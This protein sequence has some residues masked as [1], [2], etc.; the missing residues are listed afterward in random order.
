MAR[1][2]LGLLAFVAVAAIAQSPL[3]TITGTITDAQEARVPN[4]EVTARNLGTGI[5]Y[6]SVSSA[7][8]TYVLPNLPVGRYEVSATA[9]GFKIYRRTDVVLEVAHRLRLDIRLELG[10]LTETVTVTGEP[11]RVRTEDATLGTVVERQRIEELPLNGRHVFSLVRLVAG[12]RPI[13]R[14]LDGFAEVTN[15]G[16]SQI[17]FNGGPVYG[18]Q[19]FIDG[20]MNTVPVH[21]EI[22]VVP[23]ADAVEEFKV[24][25]N[26]L[27]AEFGQTSGGV[28]NVA[29]KSGT[30]ELHGSL[31]EFFRNDALDARNAFAT[32]RDPLTGRIKPVL[33]YNQYGGTVGG[34]IYVPQVY[35]GRN[36][37]FF[38]FGYEQWR[39][40]TSTLRRQT[41]PTEAQRNGDFST[42]Y[43]AAG[44]VIPLFDPATTRPNPAGSGFVRDPLPGNLVPRARM[45]AV[46]LKV[47]E[48]MPKPNVTPEVPLTNSLNF[49][50]L[51][52]D[53][54][55]QGV[56]NLRV[57]HRFSD[58][59]SVFFRYSGTRNTRQGRGWGLGVADPDTFARRDQRDNHNGIA[60]YTRVV[61]PSVINELK[62]NVTR[63]NL[64]FLHPSF[65]Q[66]LP[67]KLGLPAIVPRE[68]FPRVE[69]AGMLPLG[70]TNFAAGIRAQHYLQLADSLTVVRGRHNLKFG[71]DQR[72]FRLNWRRFGYISG[73]YTFTAALT[74]DPQRP[75]GTGFG[76]ATFLLG[77]VSGGLQEFLPAFSFHAWSNG[78][79]IQDDFK[80]TRRLTLNLG[81]RYDF[82]S[83]PVERHNRHS[84]FEP[85][86]INPETRMLGVLK[87]A[88][89]DDPRHFVNRDR[90]N[91]GPRFGF[92]YD[93]T[94]DGRTAVRG[95]YGLVYLL[96][97]SGDTQGDDSNAF[98]FSAQTSFVPVGG[99]PFKAFSFS[100]GPPTLIV[101]LGPRGGPSAF[102]GQTVRWQDRN[103]RTPYLQQW[104]LT[105]Q[106]ELPGRW[107][108]SVSYAG[109]KG[110]K[111]FGANY[112]LNQL[113]PVHFALGL[114]L[115]DRV[116]N[117]FFG[118]IATGALSG[119]T[120]SRSQL[121]LPFPDY[122]TVT[123]YAN[124]G[125]SSIYHSLQVTVERR[126]HRGLS[127]LISYTN[128]KLINDS[129]ST[130]GSVGTPGEFRLG[131]FNRRLERA[132]D[133]NDVTHRLV[134]SAVY[135]L[136]FG[137][138]K[139]FLADAKGLLAHLA[140]GWQVNTITTIESGVPLMVRGANNFTG[141]NF[142]DVIRDPTLPRS[143]RSVTRWFDTGAFRNPPNFVVGN[144]P[145]TLPNTRGPGMFDV[146]L[147][148]F[149]NFRLD[150]GKTLE[151]RAEAF[152]ALNHVNLN[153]PNTSFQPDAQ[154]VNQ[155]ALFGRIS[156][157]MDARRIQFGLRLTF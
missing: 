43:D 5:L 17:Q 90:N 97:E 92:A 99:G 31:Y 76:M 127:A 42:T 141:I 13:N 94:G 10:A 51:A 120:V 153:N 36:R 9:P 106:R 110:T 93:L 59:D 79:Y 2:A 7:D 82:N 24:E 56:T 117:P 145:R 78:S 12:V 107:V 88:G 140:G 57:D 18:N 39:H 40:R 148:V 85:F 35:D 130:A 143:E 75:A 137:P 50:S 72:W 37:T 101:P 89:V 135:E 41:V 73:Q 19:F 132:I 34:P 147:S 157:A 131:R 16:F 150:E 58:R 65:G 81:L 14:A 22:S 136:P 144:A 52:A 86:V 70:A 124:H 68:L 113:D 48:F 26:A 8:G 128:S 20:G 53:K 47:L 67:E 116:P 108:A 149:K 103:A 30:N 121:L 118:Q 98:G 71:T 49:L 123:T 66:N 154:G 61:S 122:L 64:P 77:E 80:V 60:T 114:A 38:F 46:A 138:G 23:M 95:G 126:F 119:S 102:R 151:F 21:N 6:K 152:N 28:V 44:R 29:T 146:A 142:P 3:G 87:Y 74:G 139:P 100:Q 62:A 15:Q 112:N 96:T 125:S 69:I 83:A 133:Q 45:D 129:F 109:N 111:L 84:N 33:R 115:Q 63:Q 4:V 156:S 27:K 134:A 54:I 155:N 104:N 25:T 55:N 105:L 11:S 91:F 32:Q 1:R